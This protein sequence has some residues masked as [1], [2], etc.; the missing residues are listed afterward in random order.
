MQVIVL[1]LYQR[2]VNF[3]AQN[4]IGQYGGYGYKEH[5]S[6]LAGMD[7]EGWT[8]EE[9]LNDALRFHIIVIESNVQTRSP[10]NRIAE[11]GGERSMKERSLVVVTCR[12]TQTEGIGGRP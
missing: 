6:Q 10:Y 7:D 8:L 3:I 4:L 9:R 5:S 1:Q 12:R 2:V 11:I